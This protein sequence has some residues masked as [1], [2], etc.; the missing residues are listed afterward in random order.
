MR[1]VQLLT[2]DKK[3]ELKR[4]YFWTE[5]PYEK[6]YPPALVGGKGKKKHDYLENIAT[7]D[8]ETTSIN[9]VEEPYGFMYFWGDF[10]T[11]LRWIA[12]FIP[13]DWSSPEF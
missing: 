12:K 11:D 13:G 7:F 8:I 6:L 3:K 9:N 1:V 5:F 4:A 2:A 10:D